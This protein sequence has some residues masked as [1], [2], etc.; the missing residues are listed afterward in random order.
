MNIATRR[1]FWRNKWLRGV[2]IVIAVG[3]YLY[4]QWQQPPVGYAVTVMAIIAAV[5]AWLTEIRPA[6]KGIWLLILLLFMSTEIKAIKR[7]RKEQS[8]TFGGIVAGLQTA[9]QQG[10]QQTKQLGQIVTGLKKAT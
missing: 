3:V 1:D 4:F 7:D 6:E 2:L 5:T 9:I 10:T 8:D